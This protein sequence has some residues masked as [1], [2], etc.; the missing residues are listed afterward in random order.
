M[1]DYQVSVLSKRHRFAGLHDFYRFRRAQFRRYLRPS[2]RA[3]YMLC[4]PRGGLNDM[5][6]QISACMSYSIANHRHLIIDTSRSGIL[7]GFSDVFS[8]FLPFSDISMAGHDFTSHFHLN[9]CTTWPPSVQGRI[10]D[11]QTCRIDQ[12][13]HP[14]VVCEVDSLEPLTIDFSLS[15]PH[16]LIV[17]EQFGGGNCGWEALSYFVLSS[18]FRSQLKPFIASL[19]KG[20]T[21]IHIRHTDIKQDYLVFL[22]S[23]SPFVRGGPIYLSTDSKVVIDYGRH[24]LEGSSIYNYC[25]PPENGGEPLHGNAEHTNEATTVAALADLIALGSSKTLYI[26]SVAMGPTSGF[27]TLAMSLHKKPWL[28]RQL[29]NPPLLA[30]ED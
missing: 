23:L 28:L 5:L 14:H 29:L 20:Y 24:F 3:A 4:R 27:A 17:H 2:R 19:P 13:F 7:C 26:P 8:P 9:Q 21:G 25:D 30:H 18:R 16:D 12:G 10:D 22:N 15:Y 11:Y 6:V 1:L